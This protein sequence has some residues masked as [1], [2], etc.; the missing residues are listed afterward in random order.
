VELLR[1][2]VEREMRLKRH[3][4]PGPLGEWLNDE[5]AAQ[6]AVNMVIEEWLRDGEISATAQ[7]SL[8]WAQQEGV[9]A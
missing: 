7:E 2:G 5:L 4:N 8:R 6:I 1:H 9:P 3:T